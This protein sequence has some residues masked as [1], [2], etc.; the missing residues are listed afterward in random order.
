MASWERVELVRLSV[1]G[2]DSTAV[3]L[4]A[5]VAELLTEALRFESDADASAAV[6]LCVADV[7]SAGNA[8]ANRTLFG[9]EE[10]IALLCHTLTSA[11]TSAPHCI[12]AALMALRRMCGGEAF[13]DR[14]DEN[15]AAAVE[16][17]APRAVMAAMHRYATSV[18]V[19]VWGSAALLVIG[20]GG[21]EA[22]RAVSQAGGV[23][24]LTSAMSQHVASVELQANAVAAL[25]NIALVPDCRA[26]LV[27]KGGVVAVLR[28]MSVHPSCAAV[29]EY[30]C[31]V[32]C[33]VSSIAGV[34]AM[35][36][37]TDGASDAAA[38]AA[39][40]ASGAG[41]RRSGLAIVVAG[42]RHHV[43][44]VGVQHFGVGLFMTLSSLPEFKTVMMQSGGVAAV[45]DALRVHCDEA[46]VLE[47]SCDVIARLAHNDER[48]AAAADAAGAVEAVVLAMRS[49]RCV[50][51][52]AAVACAA[53]AVLCTGSPQR[54]A[55][56]AACGAIEAVVTIMRGNVALPAVQ[57]HACDALFTLAFIADSKRR[58]VAAGGVDAIVVA[59]RYHP[60]E[61][62]VQEFAV[63]ALS[64]LA[65]A[66]DA[67]ALIL[68]SDAPALV[69]EA[70]KR[71]P[72]NRNIHSVGRGGKKGGQCSVM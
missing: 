59:M 4:P 1:V 26:E 61:V 51:G 55:A 57:K 42:M 38:A 69:A 16:A 10:W 25:W 58:I 7:C 66:S 28:A 5:S 19:A 21:T 60:S 24:A 62:T 70:K 8:V 11:G 15:I 6:W 20:F 46:A 72:G 50:A 18:S 49:P 56:A 22:A 17:A 13:V 37:G 35:L 43:A 30:G 67:R 54:Q 64:N 3:V 36:L 44:V 31:R 12:A 68:A 47:H 53:V 71:F 32:L 23:A 40:A 33:S 45:V 39:A 27:S 14:H 2:G 9:S 63:A 29:Q 34:R 52:A 65:L 48:A 41:A